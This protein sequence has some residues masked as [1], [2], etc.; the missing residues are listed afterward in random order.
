MVK[1]PA[2]EVRTFTSAE[3]ETGTATGLTGALGVDAGATAPFNSDDTN[4]A[5][6]EGGCPHVDVPGGSDREPP[7]TKRNIALFN[8]GGVLACPPF[9]HRA[10]VDSGPSPWTKRGQP[11]PEHRPFQSGR[12]GFVHFPNYC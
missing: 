12:R 11:N 6:G 9:A 10:S 4:G 8:L 3:L 2:G 5:V 7:S 1:V